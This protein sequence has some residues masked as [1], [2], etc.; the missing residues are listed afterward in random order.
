MEPR[1]ISHTKRSDFGHAVGAGLL[2]A[3]KRSA[4]VLY[5]VLIGSVVSLSALGQANAASIHFDNQTRV[6]RIDAGDMSY[7]FGINEKKQM[8]ALYWG[9]RLGAADTFAA[10]HSGHDL[11]GFDTSINVTQ[12]EFTGWGEASMLSLI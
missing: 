12:Q 1:T 7:V 3:S 10:P 8:Q 2:R 11:A 6:F 4:M 9:K 5:I